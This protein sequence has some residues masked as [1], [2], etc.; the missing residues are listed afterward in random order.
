MT[1][2]T[3]SK[4]IR[5]LESSKATGP[6]EIP[7]VVLKNRSPEISPIL[8][9]LFNRCLKEKCFPT[10]WKVS[11]VC[12]V[13]KNAGER[14]SSSQYR[15]ISLLSIISKIF[16]SILNK[17]LVDYLR[18]NNLL[19]DVQ[20]GFRSSRSTVDVLTVISHRISKALDSNFDSRA[21][22]LDI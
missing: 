4:L 18:A 21:I 2:R 5:E 9:K 15:P 8:A 17:H 19:H 16:E 22:T 20:Y 6:D 1:V 13:F 10:S 7:A 12:P 14:S 11:S 3:V